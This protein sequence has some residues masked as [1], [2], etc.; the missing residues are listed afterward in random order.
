MRIT[1]KLSHP[2]LL[3][4]LTL[5]AATFPQHQAFAGKA[6]V[7]ASEAAPQVTAEEF[8]K[9]VD[10]KSA[11]VI[12]A[13]G[14]DMYAGG[15]VPGALSYAQNEGKLASVLPK[16]KNALI[17]AYC[18]GPL[19][20]AW[21]FPAQEA[22]KLGYTNIKHFKGGIKGWKDAGYPVETAKGKKS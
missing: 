7:K 11:F 17:V 16:D 12:D 6:E 14:A 22:K 20:T 15:H 18:G 13:N 8:K 21:E 19:C 1:R 4:F 9:L 10:T 3:A 5:A 2:C